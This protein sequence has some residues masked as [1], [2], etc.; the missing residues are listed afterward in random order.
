[1]AVDSI[2]K[3][4]AALN[5]AQM[6]D[7]FPVT[8]GTV[9][10]TDR[11]QVAGFYYYS[12]SS[13]SSNQSI[14]LAQIFSINGQ[15]VPTKASVFLRPQLNNEN[16][17][18][19]F[20]DSVS[21]DSLNF[22]SLSQGTNKIVPADAISDFCGGGYLSVDVLD[23]TGSY[24][25]VEYPIQ[26]TSTGQYRLW[27]RSSTFTGEFSAKIFLDNVDVGNIGDSSSTSS[28]EWNFLDID[29]ND[30]NAHV[31]KI[32]PTINGSSIDKIYITSDLTAVVSDTGPDLSI[33]PYITIHSRIYAVDN[34]NVPVDP[35][36]IYDYITTI[37]DLRT[38]DWYN[39]DLKFL[40]SSRA[41]PFSRSYALVLYSSGSDDE[42]YI[43]WETVDVGDDASGPSAI[44]TGADI[45][46]YFFDVDGNIINPWT[47][48]TLSQLLVLFAGTDPLFDSKALGTD[49]YTEIL[50]TLTDVT[51]KIHVAVSSNDIVISL[52]GG[53]TD[54]F[55]VKANTNRLF[56]GLSIPAG[57]SIMAKNLVAGSNYTD[58]YISVW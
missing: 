44:K 16:N 37:S 35:L 10:S 4:A 2:Q 7:V 36:F 15:F 11:W 14:K 27:L 43:V 47:E 40:D 42:K 32:R 57:S 41:I 9:D 33:A 19:L 39:F 49:A 34:N 31:L 53:V 51:H 5:F 56:T 50:A 38:D 48:D 28:W 18:F 3:R 25:D 26:S 52:D 30:T 24:A 20:S 17:V 23:A 29:I 46:G 12:S 22:S 6:D 8:D 55:I 54:H 21:I 13:S 1:M 58:I 45:G